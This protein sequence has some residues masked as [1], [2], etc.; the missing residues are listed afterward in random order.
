[1]RGEPQERIWELFH[2]ALERREGERPA[3]ID[4]ACGDDRV[5]H[6]AVEQLLRSHAEAGEFLEDSPLRNLAPSDLSP[7]ALVGELIDQRYRLRAVI[8]EGGMGVVYRAEQEQPI[9]RVVALKLIRPGMDTTRVLARFMAERQ[10]MAELEHP[11]I[12]R[13]Y[14]AGTTPRGRPYFV[15]EYIPGVPIIE[16]CDTHRCGTRERVELFL[17]VC[18][19]VHYAHQRGIIH[20]DLK[21]SNV[22]VRVR[23]S[24]VGPKIID[25]GVAKALGLEVGQR[26]PLT[27]QG[28]VI[29]THGYMSPEQAGLGASESPSGPGSEEDSTGIDARTDVYS[30]GVLLYEL[31]VGQTPFAPDPHYP[32]ALWQTDKKPK[33]TAVMPPS[34]LLSQL[35]GA[36][37]AV[38]ARRGTDATSLQQQLRADLDQIV[39][40]AIERDRRRRYGS[41]AEFI[42][43]LRGYLGREPGHVGSAVR[44]FRAPALRWQLAGAIAGV[45]ILALGLLLAQ[46][47]LF[48]T[49]DPP[50]QMQDRQQASRP[51]LMLAVLPFANLSGDPAQD[52]VSDGL[53]DEIIARLGRLA[54]QRLGVIA[55]TTILQYKGTGKSIQQIGKELGIDHVLEGTVRSAANRFR[56]TTQLVRVSDQMQL[57]SKSYDPKLQDILQAQIEISLRVAHS[58]AVEVLPGVRDRAKRTAVAAPLA[59]DAYLSGLTRS[60]GREQQQRITHDAQAEALGLARVASA[61]Q[62]RLVEGS[63]QF[64]LALA[65]ARQVRNEDPAVCSRFMAERLEPDWRYANLGVIN[66]DGEIWCSALPMSGPVNVS[67]RGFFQ[68]ALAGRDLSVGEFLVGRITGRASLNIGYPVRDQARGVIGVVFAAVDLAWLNDLVELAQ[69]PPGSTLTVIDRRGMVLARHPDAGTWVGRFLTEAPLVRAILAHRGEGTIEAPGLD[70]IHRLYA[71]TPVRRVPPGGDVIVSVGIPE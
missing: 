61:E 30:L 10:A 42:A 52:Y 62:E 57:W 35:G 4:S 40:Q 5:L 29:G 38:A 53:T 64:L 32:Y 45:V 63:R 23:E 69:L 60:T 12:A 27:E 15:M 37:E 2:A 22:L 66:P 68:Q 34:S 1:M 56:I 41:V 44:T 43:A 3:F 31:L 46:R 54:P 36:S 9:R 58:L 24:Q 71:F 17:Q 59:Q 19:A 13:I 48:A 7:E 16:Y 25:F 6:R 28:Q 39:L 14:D 51:R 49:A 8:G 18:D 67:D 70:G 26:T 20:R 50:G 55:R 11:N 33:E 65:Q 47:W 21:P